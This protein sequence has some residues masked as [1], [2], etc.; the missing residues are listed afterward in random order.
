MS[1]LVCTRRLGA[2]VGAGWIPSLDSVFCVLFDIGREWGGGGGGGGE[3]N[4]E[5]SDIEGVVR[6]EKRKMR[7]VKRLIWRK[8]GVR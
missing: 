2:I 5:D 7:N 8:V 1:A 3:E 4:Q 6:I